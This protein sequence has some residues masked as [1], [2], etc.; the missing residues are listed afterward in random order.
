MEKEDCIK[1]ILSNG[2]NNEYYRELAYK[3][4]KDSMSRNRYSNNILDVEKL[5]EQKNELGYPV[6]TSIYSYYSKLSKSEDVTSKD[7]VFDRLVFDFD[8]D[9]GDKSEGNY[10][11]LKLNGYKSTDLGE[12][13]E[14]E[15]KQLAD[16]IRTRE[17]EEISKCSS[18]DEIRKYYQDKYEHNYLLEPY[19][20]ARKVGKWFKDK[21]NVECLYF[22]TSGKGVHVYILFNPIKIKNVNEVVKHIA[23]K[24]D[25]GLKL[26]TRDKSVNDSA[27][28]H[29]IRIPTSKH[30]KTK[31]YV[32]Q[33]FQDDTYLDMIDNSSIK[34][35][36]SDIK[37]P[38]NDTGLLEQTLKQLDEH[39]SAELKNK[40]VRDESISKVTYTM[41]KNISELEKMF[42]KIY[43]QG[44]MNS[45]GFR[46]IHLCYRSNIPKS[47]VEN[48]FKNL[49][50]NQDLK[51]V[52]SWI[53]RT[54][55]LDLDVD[56]VGGLQLF[57][58]GIKEYSNPKDTNSLIEFFTNKFTKKD[59]V[60]Y[61]DLESFKMNRT[62]KKSKVTAKLVNKKYHSIKIHDV[63]EKKGF[64]FIINI[65]DNISIFEVRD[66]ESDEMIISQS[67]KHKYEKKGYSLKN[68][69]KYNKAVKILCDEY[70][71]PKLKDSFIM[72]VASYLSKYYNI[73]E[74]TNKPDKRDIIIN[75]VVSNP[76]KTK[77][78]TDLAELIEDELSIR[79]TSDKKNPFYY[80]DENTSSMELLDV[81]N[82]G[83][84][85]LKDYGIRLPISEVKK[86][87]NSIHGTEDIDNTVWEFSDNYY[88]TTTSGLEVQHYD[89]IITPKKLGFKK[90]G[91][92]HFFE[93]NPS[94]K[95]LNESENR[96]LTETTLRKI[97]IP[98]NNPTDTS[99]YID[100]LERLG[101]SFIENNIHKSITMYLG[102]G[103]NGKSLLTHILRLIFKEYY[104]GIEPKELKKDLFN[105]SRVGG[106]HIILVDELTSDSLMGSWD[107]LKRYS[108]G[109]SNTTSREM[110]SP[111][112]DKLNTYGMMFLLTNMIPEL[113]ID[114]KALLRRLDIHELPNR[115]VENP[116]KKDEYPII[117]HIEYK[118]EKDFEGLDWL[119]NASI[120]AYNTKKTGTFSLKQ[121]YTDTL[122][123][124][125]D[126]D[127][128][129]DYILDYTEI[130]NGSTTYNSDLITGYKQYCKDNDIQLTESITEESLSKDMGSKLKE[131]YSSKLKKGKF[132]GKTHYNISIK[133]KEEV[134]SMKSIKIYT[135]E[136]YDITS[137]YNMSSISRN[138][139]K[140]I[141]NGQAVTK[142]DLE[143]E[144]DSD[145][146]KKALKELEDN[147]YIY[148]DESDSLE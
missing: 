71:V 113:P 37:I 119:I 127:T 38:N 45:M 97:F 84:I 125:R 59:E 36:L 88:L 30:Q 57:I 58:E 123:I 25:K 20:E 14:D 33:F 50:V 40:S 79:K 101:A 15:I 65:E 115:F 106:K 122:R 23:E 62:S 124:I 13:S 56:K 117:Q 72:T 24:L 55:S 111:D 2:E 28:N 31:L 41:D 63:M 27:S 143:K 142:T 103:D 75:N 11:L 112:T 104:I 47:D 89:P 4:S 133:S 90:D 99:I 74:D 116:I 10:N 80:L 109:L 83:Y 8:V 22:F 12:L 67:L 134:E 137:D 77:Y 43:Y 114:D 19:N 16:N 91:K 147:D 21:F 92:F 120:I 78:L 60:E 141:E 130:F 9:V 87:I 82:L 52:Q 100:F 136:E 18:E 126:T 94:I 32:N 95:L 51:K 85:L 81:D 53:D 70:G 132:N 135:T 64:N 145:E 121:S 144:Y 86:V 146:V 26:K 54:Y 44:C 48:F 129:L 35:S 3:I 7:V 107:I 108:N 42:T 138:V 118:L 93:Y 131:I 128:L 68:E 102:K 98:K 139:Y 73:I 49:Q 66:S 5:I 46:F 17:S 29:L 140:L 6:Y 148:Y 61:I 34:Y 105:S 1:T 110:Y 76:T 69:S 39:I 96:T